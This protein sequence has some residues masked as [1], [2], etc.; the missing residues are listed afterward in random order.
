MDRTIVRAS[1]KE[2]CDDMINHRGKRDH[3]KLNDEKLKS[4]SCYFGDERLKGI[5]LIC[6]R[7]LMEGGNLEFKS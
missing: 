7:V 6:W 3:G 2:V 1:A 5:C 4:E